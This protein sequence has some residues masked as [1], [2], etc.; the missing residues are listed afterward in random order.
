MSDTTGKPIIGF[1]LGHGDTALARTSAEATDAPQVMQIHGSNLSSG[2]QCITAVNEQPD[3]T[4]IIGDNAIDRRTG[5]LYLG[6]KGPQLAEEQ[7]RHPTQLFSRQIRDSLYAESDLRKNDSVSWVFGCP[8]GWPPPLRAQYADLFRQG[9]FTQAEVVTESRA[10]M[11]YARDSGEVKVDTVALNGCVLVVDLGSS[12]V[13]F[14]AVVRRRQQELGSKSG[15]RLELRDRGTNLGA[16]LIEREIMERVLR[17]HP[18][19]DLLDEMLASNQ[20]ARLKLEVTCRKAKEDYFRLDNAQQAAGG[21]GKRSEAFEV[22]GK[23]RVWVNILVTREDMESVLDTPLPALGGRSWREA[24]RDDLRS[25]TAEL[26]RKPDVVL[27]TGGA[28]RMGFVLEVVREMFGKDKVLRGAE[29]EAAIARGLAIAGRIGARTAGFTADVQRLLRSEQVREL[30]EERL[31]DLA[32]R[33]GAAATKGFTERHVIPAFRRWRNGDIR[34]LNGMSEEIARSFSEELGAPGNQAIMKAVAE[35]QDSLRPQ[36]EELTRP[37]CNKWH[38]PATALT[39]PPADVSQQ[40][41]NIAPV[42]RSGAATDFMTGLSGVITGVVAGI[43]SA[44]ILAH[45]LLGPIG[46]VLGIITGAFFFAVGK[47]KAKEMIMD[48]DLPRAARRMQGEQAVLAKLR[49]EAGLQ[50][51]ELGRTLAVQIVQKS[52]SKVTVEISTALERELETLADEAKFL[53]E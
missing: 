12:T 41:W 2:R 20:N 16:S 11:L 1:D 47:D 13:D 32:Q 34:T 51:T 50:E 39:L 43:L 31:P 48:M 21:E 49:A 40:G 46:V 36:L 27:L 8:S 3:G 19:R 53:I 42:D 10:A 29:P 37:I 33:V 38:L 24:F 30:T 26:K 6:F 45:L 35:W 44:V 25:A 9:G 18:Q 22:P 15:R 7:V 52:G 28:S 4:V 17:E 5:R 23:G 14:T